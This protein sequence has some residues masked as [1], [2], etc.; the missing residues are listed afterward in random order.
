MEK[1]YVVNV[2]NVGRDFDPLW[3]DPMVAAGTPSVAQE[4]FIQFK[5]AVKDKVNV[6]FPMIALFKDDERYESTC[7]IPHSFGLTTYLIEDGKI[8]SPSDEKIPLH[9]GLACMLKGEIGWVGSP[10]IKKIDLIV[11]FSQKPLYHEE[12]DKLDY[13][14]KKFN[15]YTNKHDVQSAL[16]R[17]WNTAGWLR[18]LFPELSDSLQGEFGD[19]LNVY[20][21]PGGLVVSRPLLQGKKVNPTIGLITPGEYAFDTGGNTETMT[22]L[23]GTLQAGVDGNG[24]STLLK[25]QNIV[26]PAGST[27]NLKAEKDV[28]YLCEYEP[29]E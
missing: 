28:F 22:V 11:E 2:S 4:R 24:K 1:L 13:D 15:A 16:V 21:L 14:I 27:L 12:I 26:A 8:F 29:R 6:P 23:E 17:R 18:E 10:E 7:R 25:G 9:K 19:R 3:L 20:E 5:K